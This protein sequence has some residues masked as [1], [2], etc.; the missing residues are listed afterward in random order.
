[1][2]ACMMLSSFAYGQIVKDVPIGQL[3]FYQTNVIVF[4]QNTSIANISVTWELEDNT[5][6][7]QSKSVTATPSGTTVQFKEVAHFSEFG[8][9]ATLLGVVSMRITATCANQF[10]YQEF[11]KLVPSVSI[12]F[13]GS[14][15]SDLPIN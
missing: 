6:V 15:F 7:T 2:V 11:D 14:I 10:Y 4:A 9:S 1:M 8:N 13:R 5:F 12:Y 3:P